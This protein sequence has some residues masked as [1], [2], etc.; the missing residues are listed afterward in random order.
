MAVQIMNWLARVPLARKFLP[1]NTLFVCRGLAVLG[2]GVCVPM[3]NVCHVCTH[4]GA[5]VVL[6]DSELPHIVEVKFFTKFY[7]HYSQKG[8]KTL[9]NQGMGRGSLSG[10]WRCGCIDCGGGNNSVERKCGGCAA[11]FWDGRLWWM[12]QTAPMPAPVLADGVVLKDLGSA[13]FATREA[14][15]AALRR[16][17]AVEFQKVQQIAIAQSDPEIKSRLEAVREM[18][19][20]V[21]AASTGRRG[22]L[23]I[24]FLVRSGRWGNHRGCRDQHVCLCQWSAP[25]GKIGC[26]GRGDI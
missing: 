3:P 11:C 9:G 22:L 23:G 4:L 25:G 18:V 15:Q 2:G 12:G 21:S 5:L 26:E 13:D 10:W 20:E 19:I 17:P 7:G 24:R 8:T 16:V 14:A 1:Q 6:C